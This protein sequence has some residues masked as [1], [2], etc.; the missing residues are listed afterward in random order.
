MVNKTAFIGSIASVGILFGIV[1]GEAIA[2]KSH[3]SH[4]SP[5]AQTNQFQPIEQPLENKLAVT[6]GGLGLIGLQLWWFLLSKPKTQ[7][8]VATSEDVQELTV[9]VDGGYDPSRIVVEAGKAVRIKFE[10]KD[11]SSC[12]EQVVLPDFYIAKDLPL[13]QVTTVEFTPEQPGIYLFTCGMNMFRGEIRAETSN[14]TS[15]KKD[16]Q[17]VSST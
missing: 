8:A 6:L 13:N 3:D 5:T 14:T 1:S 10:R 2:Q 4:P 11:P 15:S 16:L 12:L 17:H 9:T 7:T